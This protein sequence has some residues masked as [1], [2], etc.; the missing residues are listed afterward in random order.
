[1]NLCMGFDGSCW[2]VSSLC[3]LRIQRAQRAERREKLERERE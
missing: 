1:M 2:A 3:E